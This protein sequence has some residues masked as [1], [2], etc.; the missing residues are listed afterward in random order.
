MVQ[1][2]PFHASATVPL[3]PLLVTYVPA[4][5]QA[6][7]DGQDTAPSS[8]AVTPAGMGVDCTCQPVP[9]HRSARTTAAP[10]LSLE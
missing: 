1:P 9:F 2:E 6:R 7:S 10:V 4:A 5:V 3:A 8:L